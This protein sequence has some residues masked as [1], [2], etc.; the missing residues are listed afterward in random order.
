MWL[1]LKVWPSVNVAEF[2]GN[3]L[4]RF[5]SRPKQH[6]QTVLK[7]KMLGLAIQEILAAPHGTPTNRW[8]QSHLPLRLVG[9][10]AGSELTPSA[11]S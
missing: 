2:V 11:S 7:E 10:L 1:S 8:F 6:G 5:A 9:V 4:S 3:V